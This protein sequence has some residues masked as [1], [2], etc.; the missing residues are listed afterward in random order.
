MAKPKDRLS[1][2]DDVGEFHRKFGLTSWPEKGPH[3]ATPE[4][5]DFR[6]KF[7]AEE[8]KEIGE[9]MGLEVEIRWK[10][11]GPVGAPCERCG[12]NGPGFYNGQIH[13]C[14]AGVQDLAKIADGLIDLAYVVKG[15]AHFYGLPWQDLWDEVQRA[16]MSKRRAATDGSDS[17]RKSR[18]DVVKPADFVPPRIH[19]VLLAAGWPGPELPLVSEALSVL[20]NKC[21]RCHCA[22]EYDE[23]DIGV[24]V[25]Q[26]NH[27]CPNCGWAPT[28]ARLEEGE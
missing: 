25:Q 7:M 13:P 10:P 2:F 8:L 4:E 15:T 19:D 5:R 28:P 16:N 9:G 14:A 23:V 22:L 3:L 18:L 6:F 20:E 1:N 27:R 12:Y 11:V 21:P 17:T 26:G 24:G